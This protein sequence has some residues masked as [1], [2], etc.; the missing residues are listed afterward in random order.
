VKTLR[1][2]AMLLL[3][4][5]V[6][7]ACTPR[8]VLEPPL[9]PALAASGEV[10]SLLALMNALGVAESDIPYGEFTLFA[11]NDATMDAYALGIL[12]DLPVAF[13]LIEGNTLEGAWLVGEPGDFELGSFFGDLSGTDQFF[14]GLVFAVQNFAAF[15][16]ETDLFNGNNGDAITTTDL[17]L[18]VLLDTLRQFV[19]AHVVPVQNLT[20]TVSDY[21]VATGDF[22]EPCPYRATTVENIPGDFAAL[23]FVGVACGEVGSPAEVDLLN[24]IFFRGPLNGLQLMNG[25]LT[26]VALVQRQL[27]RNGVI[28]VFS[29]TDVAVGFDIELGIGPISLP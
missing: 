18:N 21:F 25:G 10:D 4:T 27:T 22:A 15:Y 2:I 16:S 8:Q 9:L 29:A 17:V 6:I 3:L 13:G 1:N 14:N 11:P 19:L 7:A 24:A 12:S 28:W 23:D 5:G 26:P 20:T